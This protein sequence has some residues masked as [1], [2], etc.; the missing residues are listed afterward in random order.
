MLSG[1][2]EWVDE[3]EDEDWDEGML[4]YLKCVRMHSTLVVFCTCTFMVVVVG[5]AWKGW[6]VKGAWEMELALRWM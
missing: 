1:G 2:T 3:D 4:F 6:L 5:D